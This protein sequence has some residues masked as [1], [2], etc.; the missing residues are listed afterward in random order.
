VT[1]DPVT[2]EGRLSVALE[3]VVTR[4]ADLLRSVAR[5]YRVGDGDMAEVVQEVRVRLW[6]ARPSAETIEGLGVSYIYRTA[7][8]AAL[9]VIQRRRDGESLV[10]TAGPRAGQ[11]DGVLGRREVAEQVAVAMGALAERRRVV[12]RMHLS[13]YDRAEIARALG[14]SEATVRNLIYRGLADLRSELARRGVGP[15]ELS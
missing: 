3:R 8:S 14:W 11:P 4:F 13:G 6:R 2:D 9:T 1:H 12:V 10:E 5:R 15:E 7:V